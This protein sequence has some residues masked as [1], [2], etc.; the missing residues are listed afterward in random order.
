MKR[1]RFSR[2]LCCSVELGWELKLLRS[3]SRPSNNPRFLCAEKSVLG[4]GLGRGGRSD[5]KAGCHRQLEGISH[6]PD[7]GWNAMHS[8]PITALSNRVNTVRQ[9]TPVCTLP[10][11]STCQRLTVSNPPTSA[12]RIWYS[13][14]HES[15]VTVTN[16]PVWRF[17]RWSDMTES[18]TQTHD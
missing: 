5:G 12:V 9:R 6:R 3:D 2:S 14:A 1:A 7:L 8:P 10:D 15:S 18:S 13:S 16:F 4:C 11:R 17:T